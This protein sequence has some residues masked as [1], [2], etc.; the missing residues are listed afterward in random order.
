[1]TADQQ[2]L[3]LGAALP[4]LLA[5][6]A[7]VK[8]LFAS[9]GTLIGVIMLASFLISLGLAAF[10]AFRIPVRLWLDVVDGKVELREGRVVGREEQ[11]NRPNGRDPIEKYY[12]CLRYLNMQVSLAA[13][14][15]LEDGSMYL[16]YL[17]PRS[18][19]LVSIEPKLDVTPKAATEPK[20]EPDPA[21]VNAGEPSSPN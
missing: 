12:F 7:N 10:M 3:S 13:Y 1:M 16:V 18:E 19:V 8:C 6:L 14:R 2:H 20:V 21:A 9:H 5:D 11:Y 15:A 17:L 4:L